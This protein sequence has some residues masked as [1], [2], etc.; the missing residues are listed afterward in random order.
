M[1]H[2]LAA[3]ATWAAFTI[4]VGAAFGVG[5]HRLIVMNVYGSSMNPSIRQGDLVLTWRH[6]HYKVGDAVAYK[7]RWGNA[8]HP[9]TVLHRIMRQQHAGWTLRGDNNP[10]EDPALIAPPDVLGK[11]FATIPGGGKALSQMRSMIW[12]IALTLAGLAMLWP[13]REIDLV[14]KVEADNDFE[15]EDDAEEGCDLGEIDPCDQTG[16][17]YDMDSVT[18]RT[19]ACLL[20]GIYR[21]A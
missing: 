1:R 2:A 5:T 21:A 6:D 7:A 10:S 15:H 19:D 9:Q 20:A 11:L 13:Q 16:D 3:L 12:I 4:M 14:D 17:V 18:R 8:K